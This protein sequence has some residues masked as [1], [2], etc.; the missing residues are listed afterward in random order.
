M[1]LL[2]NLFVADMKK[3][4]NENGILHFLY[5]TAI[6]RLILK[7]LTTRTLSKTAGKFISSRLSRV[8]IKP[9]VFKNSIDLSDYIYQDINEYNSFNDFFT[10]QIKPDKRR[11]DYNPE[12]LI[13]PCDGLL[14]AYQLSNDSIIPAKQSSYTISELLGNNYELAS[15]FY[16]G[17][18]LV[19]RLCVDN[20]HRYCYFDSGLKS[21]NYFIPGKLHTV[22]PIALREIPVFTQNCREYT[23]IESDNFG[24]AVQMEIGA[25]LVGRIYNYHG[26]AKIR[27]GVEKG[28][29]LYGGST[30]ILLLEKGRVVLPDLIFESTEMGIETPVKMGEKIGEACLFDTFEK[31]RE[32]IAL[33][34]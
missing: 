11:V 3:I 12:T 4:Q 1:F 19:F 17:V 8:L 32:K 30:I 31:N 33:D 9:F 24:T 22:R 10:R 7:P 15:K 18:C 26:I 16:D 20:Y 29:F 25:L 5:S 13:A 14:S 27:R 21:D 28:K 23:V 34:S 2:L 6:G